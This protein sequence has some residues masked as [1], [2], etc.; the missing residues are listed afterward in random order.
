[1]I[2]T[3]LE[4]PNKHLTPLQFTVITKVLQKVG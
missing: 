2:E 3:P 4:Q 1:M